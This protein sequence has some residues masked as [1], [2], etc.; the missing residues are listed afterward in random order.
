MPARATPPASCTT[1]RAGS[2]PRPRPRSTCPGRHAVTDAPADDVSNAPK[3]HKDRSAYVAALQRWF[4]SQHPEATDVRVGDI[5][6]PAA[7]GFS[8]ETVF[9]DVDWSEGGEGRHERFV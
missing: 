9:F 2:R 4:A 1:R 5:D 6:I 3:F 8:N 7:T